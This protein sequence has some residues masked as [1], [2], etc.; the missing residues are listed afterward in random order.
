M[1]ANIAL[2]QRAV[3]RIGQRM[4]RHIGIRMAQKRFMM[5]DLHTAQNNRITLG[6]GVNVI[7]IAQS[8]IHLSLPLDQLLTAREIFGP[9]DF[10]ILFRARNDCHRQARRAGNLD[11]IRRQLTRRVIGGAVRVYNRLQRKSL[12]RLRAVEPGACLGAGN[13]ALRATPERIGHG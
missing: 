5:R 2:R 3:N 13:D 12:R 11:I 6:E 4:H 1:A 7:A 9:S 10:E 8:N